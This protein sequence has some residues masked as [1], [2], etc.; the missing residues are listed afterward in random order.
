MFELPVMSICAQEFLDC[1]VAHV[2]DGKGPDRRLCVPRYKLYRLV[3]LLIAAVGMVPDKQ[4][5]RRSR[6]CSFFIVPTDDGIVPFK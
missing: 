1:M 5:L 3:I 4:L 2:D 6:V